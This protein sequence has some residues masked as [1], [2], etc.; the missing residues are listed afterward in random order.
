MIKVKKYFNL[1]LLI[2][3]ISGCSM[4]RTMMPGDDK[5]ENEEKT[6]G[7]VN[8]FFDPLILND[9]ELKVRKTI[10]I[11]TT[12]DPV[13]H[14]LSKQDTSYQQSEISPGFRV[15]ICAVSDED[16]A[17]QIQR[18]AILKFINE[19]IYLI[20]DIPYYKV[21]VG[22]CLTRYEADK[23]QQLAVEKGFEDAWVVRTNIVAKRNNDSPLR[24]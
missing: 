24:Y 11:E 3:V 5:V 20:Y 23:L 6:T 4:T 1:L 8:E 19:E 12:S 21:R 22:N 18:D 7:I 17:K 15:Q 13:E 2:L 14:N 10:S 9:E 16:R